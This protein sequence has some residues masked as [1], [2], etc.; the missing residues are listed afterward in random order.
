M[1]F[2]RGE[3]LMLASAFLAGDGGAIGSLMPPC[4][5]AGLG[6]GDN[7]ATDGVSAEAG[8]AMLSKGW[9]ETGPLS[10]FALISFS[11]PPFGVK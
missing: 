8:V 1:R 4:I 2:A 9:V 7:L 11:S 6:C 3:L 10:S 5:A